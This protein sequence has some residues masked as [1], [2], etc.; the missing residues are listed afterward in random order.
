MKNLLTMQESCGIMCKS[1]RD[2]GRIQTV[3][4]LRV[5]P[6]KEKVLADLEKSLLMMVVRVNKFTFR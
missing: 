4:L 3:S 6:H 2:D 5:I 1:S